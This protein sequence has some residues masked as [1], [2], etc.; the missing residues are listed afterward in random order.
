[1]QDLTQLGQYGLI[2]VMLSL[3]ALTG[4]SIWILYK[5]V[6]NHINHNTQSNNKNSETREVQTKVLER[7]ATLIETKL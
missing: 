3:I 2:G 6:S 7:L 5:I 1:M 4:T